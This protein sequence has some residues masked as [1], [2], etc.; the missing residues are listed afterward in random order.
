MMAAYADLGIEYF[1]KTG[2][3]DIYDDAIAKLKAAEDRL[4]APK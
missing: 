1:R 4:G 3:Y 2:K